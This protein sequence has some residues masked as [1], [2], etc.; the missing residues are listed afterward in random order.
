MKEDP[1]HFMS[2]W[3]YGIISKENEIMFFMSFSF[4]YTNYLQF[5][6]NVPYITY[7]AYDK[8]YLLKLRQQRLHTLGPREKSLEK[9]PVHVYYNPAISP[10][11]E[12]CEPM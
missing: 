4:N 3:N 11:Q 5:M 9:Y 12:F 8:D 1:G 7:I 2:V 6:W 10:M